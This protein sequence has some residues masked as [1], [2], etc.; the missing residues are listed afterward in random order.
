[1]NSPKL[2]PA[3]PQCRHLARSTDRRA[4]IALT[5]AICAGHAVA[6]TTNTVAEPSATT[7][8]ASATALKDELKWLQAEKITVSTASLR[9]ESLDRAPATVRVITQRQMQERGYRTIE[10]VLKGLPGVDVLNHVHPD[11]KNVVTIRGV[12]GNNKFVILQDGIR[13][14]SPTGETNLQITENYPLYMARQVEILS[15][16]AS[17]LYGADAF[18]GVINIITESPTPEG[19]VRG[20]FA[21]GDFHTWQTS[22]FASKRFSDAVALSIGGHHQQSDGAPL[23]KLYPTD[24]AGILAGGAPYEPAFRSFSTF[25]KIE[26][27]ENLTLGW[28][29]S[30]VATS[31]A[32]AELPG[33]TTTYEGPPENPTSQLTAYAKYKFTLDERISGE[34][35]ANYSRYERLP[36]SGYRNAFTSGFVAP[37]VQAYKYAYGERVQIEP[38]ISVELEKHVLSAGLTADYSYAIPKTVDLTTPYNTGKSPG[39]QGQNYLGSAIPAKLFEEESFNTGMFLQAQ[40][41]WNERFSST[42]GLRFDYNS[43]YGQTINPRLGLVFQQTPET[44]WKML[45]GRS[46]LAPSAHLRFENFGSVAVPTTAYFFIPN[47]NLKPEQ[48]QTLELSLSHRL[49][50]ELTFGAV[51]F[52]T[53]MDQTILPVY[54]AGIGNTTFI[55]GTT[56]T[57][58]EQYQNVGELQSR[59]VE[60]TMDYT[61]KSDLSR[62]SLWGSFSFINGQVKDKITTI[63]YDLPFTSTELFKMG[64]TWNYNDRVIITPSLTWNGPQAGFSYYPGTAGFDT[65]SP[66]FFVMNLYAELRSA[67][68]NFALFV[69]ADNLLDQRYYNAGFGGFFN[70]Y[71]TPQD[72]RTI[73]V[74]VSGKF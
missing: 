22:F 54:S 11:S 72:S 43:E 49:T 23:S 6:Q 7:R 74:G 61:W 68:Q 28:N 1:M 8:P 63:Q 16:P 19:T 10:D 14:S 5:L 2:T 66:D 15:G 27:W 4:A 31:L 37:Y 47:P 35:Q 40:T 32:D 46:Y 53:L 25:A 42:V 45:Y 71:N 44:T 3:Q 24:F 70:F 39:Q 69:R 52:Y 38:R 50:D 58:T 17:A 64:A 60:L 41:E 57:D 13:I 30:F 62:L 67:N 18:T 59:G 56:I 51:A 33:A 73:T 12:T 21:G 26:L 34:V 20:S 65:R 36:H 48:L 29:Q 55:P 9:A